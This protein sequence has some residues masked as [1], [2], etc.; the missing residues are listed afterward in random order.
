MSH[1]RSNVK[2][3]QYSWLWVRVLPDVNDEI[4]FVKL[5]ISVQASVP[6]IRGLVH[7]AIFI[8]VIQIGNFKEAFTPFTSLCYGSIKHCKLMMPVSLTS[9]IMN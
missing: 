1:V 9:L 5:S 4:K 3:L 6:N 8:A 2:T 7:A